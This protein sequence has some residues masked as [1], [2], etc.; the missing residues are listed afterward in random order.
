MK[1]SPRP[2]TATTRLIRGWGD[3][4]RLGVV[5]AVA[6]VSVIGLSTASEV[7]AAIRKHISIPAQGLGAA[8]QQLA[9]EQDVQ[10]VYR[11]EVVG[12]RRTDGAF[13]ELTLQEALIKLLGGSGL[14]YEYLEGSAITII[15]LSTSSSLLPGNGE[16]SSTLSASEQRGVYRVAQNYSSDKSGLDTAENARIWDRFRLAQTENTQTTD[17]KSRSASSSDDAED[18]LVKGEAG[19]Q[20]QSRTTGGPQETEEVI[21]RATSVATK[22]E[23]PIL[24]IPQ[25]VQVIPV[26]VMQDQQA[27]GLADVVENVSGVQTWYAIG[28][29][30]DTFV[31]RGFLNNAANFRNGMRIPLSRFDLANVEYVEVLKGPSSVLYGSSD[32]GGLVNTVTKLP[33]TTPTYSIEQQ[34][35]S[36]DHFRTEA[37][38]SGPI[39]EDHTLLY[40]IDFAYLNSET[41]RDLS[42]NDRVFVAPAFSW[43]YSPSTQFNLSWDHMDDKLV[44]DSGVPAVGDRIADIPIERAFG[45]S[46]IQDE[47]KNDLIDFNFTHQ[48]NEALELKAGVVVYDAKVEDNL[49]Y[50]FA[51]LDDGD[52]LMDTYAGFG[53]EDVSTDIAWL[54]LIGE[55]QTGS[56]GHRVLVGLEYNQLDVHEEFTDIYVD[57]N[58]IF[59]PGPYNVNA[60]YALYETAPRLYIFNQD[61]TTRGIYLQDEVTLKE[62]LHLVAGLRYDELDRRLET[63]YYSPTFDVAVRNDDSVSPR[64]GL[65]YQPNS[66][67]SIYGSYVESFGPSFNYDTFNDFPPETA[68]QFELGVKKEFFDGQV[69]S[70]IAVYD[71]TKENIP[72]PDP[73]DPLNIL[74]IGEANSRGVEFDVQGRVTDALSILGSYAY[75]T[76]EI[77]RDNSGNEGNKLPYVPEHQGSIRLKYDVQNN[78]LQGLSIGGG[79]YAA[80]DRFGDSANSYSDGSYT[81]LDLFATYRVQLAK[82]VMTV[83]L[84]VNNVTDTEYYN[85]RSRWSNIPAEPIAVFGSIRLE[86]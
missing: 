45:T 15:P 1:L 66:Q 65:V 80:T 35:G 47:H 24:Q 82:S 50:A 58:N 53:S 8:L 40:R 5:I 79:V 72:T 32:P 68:H 83:Q 71:L 55:F 62:N 77:S 25:S 64:L 75:T 16:G 84:N 29:S 9:K 73:N 44:Y 41:F 27:Q 46:G 39:N 86:F 34:A 31:I 67:L 36:Y 52:E 14:T 42:D 3:F 30:Y 74:L 49:F 59:Q 10:L 2:T 19:A 13:G 78:S 70:T 33:T 85:L 57:T 6:C 43:D 60:D 61:L 48:V 28:G 37:S 26:I 51:I 4:M 22:T 21:V 69:L 11:S 12:D 17:N 38:A 23:T 81:R 7:Q 54:N 20:V 18:K 76:T 63:T 56:I